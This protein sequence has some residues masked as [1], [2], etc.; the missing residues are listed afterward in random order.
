MKEKDVMPSKRSMM[1]RPLKIE[2]SGEAI[3]VFMSVM[4]CALA[5]DS[6]RACLKDSRGCRVN[7]LV[8][9]CMHASFKDKRHGL[10]QVVCPTTEG[11]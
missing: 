7:I 8:C 11:R 2:G 3:T 6:E 1:D 5:Q 10:F 4:T 9:V